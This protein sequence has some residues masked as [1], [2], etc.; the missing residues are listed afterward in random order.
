MEIINDSTHKLE[1]NYPCSWSYKLIGYE[2]E[3]IQ[4]AIHE[5]ILEREHNLEHSNVSKGG[6]Y[7]S[8]NLDLV[9]QNEDERNFIYEALKAHQHIKMV[10]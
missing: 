10:L 5:V 6:K 8:M 3:T 9:I 7:V 2:K 4:R 1:L